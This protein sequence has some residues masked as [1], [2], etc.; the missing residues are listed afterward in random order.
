M[1][2]L[3]SLRIRTIDETVRVSHSPVERWL[4]SIRQIIVS[5]VA[6]THFVAIAVARTMVVVFTFHLDPALKRRPADTKE[7]ANLKRKIS[8]AKA[9]ITD[10]LVPLKKQ[11]NVLQNEGT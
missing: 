6:T 9:L 8:S 7:A 11:T 4:K 10:G 2:E 5:C 3:L 1:E